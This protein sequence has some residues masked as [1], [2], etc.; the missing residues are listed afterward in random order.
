MKT[1]LIDIWDKN[2]LKTTPQELISKRFRL[3][4]TI[5]YIRNYR[6]IFFDNKFE[7]KMKI[8]IDD[9]EYLEYWRLEVDIET[10]YN[11]SKTLKV[12]I[13]LLFNNNIN[14]GVVEII[15]YYFKQTKEIE[16]DFNKIIHLIYLIEY[17]YF[18]KNNDTITW[19]SF[20][21]DKNWLFNEKLFE[22]KKFFNKI[23]NNCFKIKRWISIK[24]NVLLEDKEIRIFLNK[25]F[26]KYSDFNW[27][28]LKELVFKTEPLL[29]YN[30]KDEMNKNIWIEIKFN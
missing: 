5:N 4:A 12:D 7:K 8:S 29:K 15:D 27:D 1:K 19:M 28:E 21:L 23:E 24:N 11:I 6:G 2:Y 26:E 18:K 13:E 9:F 14:L 3:G 30:N 20:F 16:L 22:I 25:M 10:L 17:E